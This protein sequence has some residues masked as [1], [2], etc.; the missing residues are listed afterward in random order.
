MSYLERFNANSLQ[1]IG[2]IEAFQAGDMDKVV[3]YVN[4][5]NRDQLRALVFVLICVAGNIADDLDLAE[6]RELHE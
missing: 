5:H 3:A 4:I 6:L 1:A 2:L